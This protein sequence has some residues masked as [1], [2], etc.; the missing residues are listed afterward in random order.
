MDCGCIWS[1]AA[2]LPAY[3]QFSVLPFNQ[4]LILTLRY[5]V[6]LPVQAGSPGE[7]HRGMNTC[8]NLLACTRGV[9]GVGVL[10]QVKYVGALI[11]TSYEVFCYF[12]PSETDSADPLSSLHFVSDAIFL[13]GCCNG[14]VFVADTRTSAAPQRSPPPAP[15]G[16]S[17][18]WWTDATGGPSSCRVLR[19][20]SSGRAVISDLRNLGGAVSQAQLDVQTRRCERDD[21][22]V[23]WAPALD[24]CI[25][26]S[27]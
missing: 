16:D 25:A 21:V 5:S 24:D 19:L 8:I 12:V 4:Q 22:R 20:S 27:G 15:S 17:V 9:F 10:A 1:V 14:S 13:A 18:L 26:V 2:P 7:H 3:F 23:S 11:S 6:H